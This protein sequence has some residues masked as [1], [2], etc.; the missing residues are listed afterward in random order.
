MAGPNSVGNQKGGGVRG[1]DAVFPGAP[2]H[3]SDGTTS[4][5]VTSLKSVRNI[6]GPQPRT[7]LFDRPSTSGGTTT[8]KATNKRETRDDLHLIVTR[9]NQV[10]TTYF[11]F[12]L[13][14]SLPP[15]SGIPRS[16]TPQ[17]YIPDYLEPELVE[18]NCTHS[19]ME[20]GMALGSPTH[21]P[22]VWSPHVQFQEATRNDSPDSFADWQNT[23]LPAK[24]KSSKWKLL[25]G[26]FGKKTTG[27]APA[28]Y[29]VQTEVQT[30]H[31]TDYVAF[32]S[33]PLPEKPRGRGKSTSEKA[34]K[35]YKPDMKR[36]QT[37]P[38]DFQ[39]QEPAERP[40]E[41]PLIP[42]KKPSPPEI[43]LDGGPMLNVDI[44]SIE[45]ERYSVMFGNLIKPASKTS[46]LLARRQA[47]LDRLKMVNEAIAEHV[48]KPF[49][50]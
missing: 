27:S 30:F 41:F 26:L 2:F 4:E 10:D 5:N 47:T 13:P 49:G 39:F 1:R 15:P 11:N 8:R 14:S 17:A 33:P 21:P 18:P 24:P 32:P 20:I 48:S 6:A 35:K 42:E 40:K 25:G 34:S 12:P 29:Q 45:M 19:P 36:S 9:A 46:S 23:P 22:V 31:Q 3:V 28:F 7:I 38:M 50:D 44:P 43:Q 16:P 37:V